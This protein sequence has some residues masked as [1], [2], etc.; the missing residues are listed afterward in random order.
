MY[1]IFVCITAWAWRESVNNNSVCV[2]IFVCS[3]LPFTEGTVMS[4]YVSLHIFLAIVECIFEGYIL[5][6]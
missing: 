2:R 5:C 3:D 1:M 6:H 4:V